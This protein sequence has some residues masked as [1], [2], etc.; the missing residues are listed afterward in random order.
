MSKLSRFISNFFSLIFSGK[1]SEALFEISRYLPDWLFTFDRGFGLQAPIEKID[2]AV[3]DGFDGY[4]VLKATEEHMDEIFD[5]YRVG[6]ERIKYSLDN[7]VSC[8][9]AAPPGMDWS[10]VGWFAY[11]NCYVRGMG[12]SY[13]FGNDPYTFGLFTKE[14]ARRKGLNRLIIAESIKE[15]KQRGS[16]TIYSMVEFTNPY[17]LS[18]HIKLGY[19]I[20]LKICYMRIFGLRISHVRDLDTNQVHRRLYFCEPKDNVTLI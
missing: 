4:R 11:G 5:V 8:F 1:F 20:F 14:E 9:L 7:G 2:A 15:A 19:R 17:A 16:S 10:S 3:S 6:L 12:F 18:F 13:D